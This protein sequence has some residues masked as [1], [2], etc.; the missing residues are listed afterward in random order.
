MTSRSRDYTMSKRLGSR[1]MN[2]TLRLE[3]NEL[4]VRMNILE[5][6][7]REEV[8]KV[9]KDAGNGIQITIFDETRNET[10]K[11]RMKRASKEEI[12]H[13]EWDIEGK[14]YVVGDQIAMYWDTTNKRLCYQIF[15]NSP[16]RNDPSKSLATSSSSS[17]FRR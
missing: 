6:F 17:S 3:E 15:P 10:K 4:G 16:L 2:G 12:F 13:I 5:H 8:K 14:G 11:T 9:M 7:P 1:E